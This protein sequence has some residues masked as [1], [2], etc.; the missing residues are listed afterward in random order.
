MADTLKTC[1]Y[2]GNI[3]QSVCP[4]VKAFEYHQDGTIKRVEFHA[5]A[6]SFTPAQWPSYP[7]P[8]F[9]VTCRSDE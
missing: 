2:C 7:A 8:P 9:T 6:P 1:P 3:H 5:G 4:R